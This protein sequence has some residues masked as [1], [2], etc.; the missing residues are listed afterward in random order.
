MEVACPPRAS[1]HSAAASA[2]ARCARAC[3]R[4]RSSRA[5]RRPTS[6]RPASRAAPSR[7]PP[8]AARW[9]TSTSGP[10]GADR[11]RRRCPHSTQ[12]RK[13]FAP[14]DFQV[15][16]VNVDREADDRE[17]VPAASARS[18]IRA[19]STRRARFPAHFGVEAMPTSFLID[20]D[21]VVRHVQRGFRES[22]VEPLREQIQQLVAKQTLQAPANAPRWLAAL[23]AARA[24]LAAAR[25]RPG[26]AV[27]ARRARAP[28]TWPG[29]P[30]RS[31]PRSA[32]TS[33]SARRGRSTAAPAEAADAAATERARRRSGRR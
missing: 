3:P 5:T 16:A 28:A 29:I 14:G 25:L 6:P 33:S 22:D 9:S 8:I 2:D 1:E 15:V 4:A 10:R 20:R 17:G 32:G 19:R 11:A 30:T 12:L 21:G 13:E 24:L 27:G 7:W 18:A 26:A 23:A 31:T